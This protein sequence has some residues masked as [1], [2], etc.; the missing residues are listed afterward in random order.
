MI[1]RARWLARVTA[2]RYGGTATRVVGAVIY[3]GLSAAH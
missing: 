1:G 2:W 3:V